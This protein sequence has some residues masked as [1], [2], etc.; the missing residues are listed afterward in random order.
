MKFDKETL[1]KQRFWV[2]LAG[3]APLTIIAI[4]ILLVIVGGQ[5]HAIYKELE[6]KYDAPKSLVKGDL[7]NRPIIEDYSKKGK[8]IKSHE[9]VIWHD[10]YKGQANLFNWP[11]ELESRFHFKDGIFARS[12]KVEQ[13]VKKDGAAGKGDDPKAGDPKVDPKAANA[14]ANDAKPEAKATDPKSG[15]PKD[16]GPKDAGVLTG[17]IVKYDKDWI[18]LQCADNKEEIVYNIPKVKV[19][20]PDPTE[21]HWNQLLIGDKVT[22]QYER[23]KYFNDPLTLSEQAAFIDPSEAGGSFTV[24]LTQVEDIITQVQPIDEKGEG[25]VRLQGYAY[26][27]GELPPSQSSFLRYV[28]GDWIRSHDI[29]EEAWL[30]QQELWIYRELYRL[31]RVANDYVGQFKPWPGD[32]LDGKGDGIWKGG[33]EKNKPYSFKN[34]YW[35]IDVVWKGGN[36]LELTMKNLLDRRQKLDIHFLVK[37]NEES[38]PEKFLVGG[39]P[40]LPKDNEGAI[41]KIKIELTKPFLPRTGIYSL[42]QVLTWETA[43]VKGI[44]SIVIGPGNSLSQRM[45][46]LQTRPL[47][48]DDTPKEKDKGAKAVGAVGR[49]GKEGDGNQRG[50]A[51]G[52]TPNGLSRDPYLDVTPQ[53]RNI[54]VA[55]AL[56][57]DQDHTDRVL[58]AFSNSRF[59]FLITE[60]LKNRYPA[61][62]RPQS[63]QLTQAASANLTGEV[64]NVGQAP[65]RLGDFEGFRGG[66]A[67]GPGPKGLGGAPKGLGTQPQGGGGRLAKEDGGFGGTQRPQRNATVNEDLEANIEMV[68]YGIVTVYQRYPPPSEP[69]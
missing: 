37:M 45:S 24:Y 27:K 53:T 29:S 69:R 35:E 9:D 31:V 66:K 16:V 28:S 3:A 23:G 62:M 63:A 52:N 33:T 30:A 61:S 5:I 44:E 55:L 20:T 56:I 46:N 6:K 19:S 59:R 68:I 17:V 50:P 32:K 47:K 67:F 43:A 1:L 2:V 54:P 10:S 12:V 41:R 58:T 11:E 64:K 36:E 40:L 65:P 25:A 22:V 26:R 60:V 51:G 38:E 21:K 57:V 8:E 48:K 39:E 15:D 42:E 34:P 49:F 18:Q 7:V 4:F 14:K 13:R